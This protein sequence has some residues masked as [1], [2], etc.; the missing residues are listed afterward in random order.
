MKRPPDNEE[1]FKEFIV[2]ALDQLL[3]HHASKPIDPQELLRLLGHA[4]VMIW[5]KKVADGS[6][7]EIFTCWQEDRLI[8][9]CFTSL[10]SLRAAEREY[11]KYTMQAAPFTACRALAQDYYPIVINPMC[12]Y[13]LMVLP[14]SEPTDAPPDA[15]KSRPH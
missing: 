6:G 14:E 1:L 12:P 3:R 10:E 4:V 8:V 2:H 13:A 11:G 15:P 9:P 7:L 5:F